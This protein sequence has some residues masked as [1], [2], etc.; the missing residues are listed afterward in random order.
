MKITKKGALIAA[1]ILA[2][3]TIAAAATVYTYKC[4]RCGLIQQYSQPGSYKCPTDGSFLS[5]QF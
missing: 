3:V 4:N 1:L 2:T 5:R